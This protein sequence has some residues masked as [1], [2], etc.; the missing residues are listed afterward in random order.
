[1]PVSCS[2]G[3]A[4]GVA[5]AR[6]VVPRWYERMPALPLAAAVVLAGFALLPAARANPRLA[7][8]FLGAGGALAAWALALWAAGR[9]HARL[10]CIERRVVKA[11]WVQ[12]CMQAT[13]LAYWGWYA[14]GVYQQIP[15]I[16]AQLVFLYAFDALLTWSRGPTWRAG[17]GPLPIILSTNLLLW[18][19]DDW[20]ILQFV[21]VATGALGKQFVQW[22]REG[23]RTHIFN[24]STFGQFLFAVVLIATGTTVQLTWG[25]EIAASFDNP[26]HI[27]TLLFLVGL[28]VQYLFGV[29]LMTLSAVC[30]LCALNIWY[31]H[32]TGVYYFI[33]ANMGAAV[34][35]G[36]HLLITDPATS[37]RSNTGRVIFGALY[38]AIYFGLY[39]VLDNLGV[40]LFWDKLLPVPFL[41]LAVP[42]IDRLARSGL[43]G[44]FNHWWETAF[45]PRRANLVH[46]GCWTAV[47]GTMLAT[48]Y[49][50]SPHP[51]AS[52]GFWKKAYEEGKPLGE[53]NYKKMLLTEAAKDS[54]P[55]YNQLG[56]LYLHGELLPENHASAANCFR[57]AC[58]LGDF[59]GC[60]NLARQFLFMG[61]AASDD[62]VE[63]GLSRIESQCAS[64]IDAQACFLLGFAYESGRGRPRDPVRAAQLYQQACE[65]GYE[66]A[67][68][69][70]KH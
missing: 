53:R 12:G 61:E 36:M 6:A 24:P 47:F 23:R 27:F 25:K 30:T 46:M 51:G 38:G 43:V 10:Y 22:T 68:E 9:R 40:P 7:G 33:S 69:R 65:K 8:A 54:G 62:A 26:P 19:R 17:F 42:L 50:E 67:C 63:L 16:V 20:F 5:D 2:A 29:T 1:M 44:R 49:V 15:N 45:D 48:G 31:T 70:L 13:I 34:F 58:E 64:G 14:P 35:L 59:D 3:A 41:N 21:M 28:V 4:P 55:A 11:H 60:D 39:R 52:I 66:P 37:P 32:E 56:I 57:R 18:F